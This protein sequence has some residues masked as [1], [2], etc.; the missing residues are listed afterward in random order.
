MDILIRSNALKD[1]DDHMTQ[2]DTLDKELTALVDE[3]KNIR[4]QREEKTKIIKEKN[5]KWDDLQ[6]QKDEA[7]AKFDKVRR[8]DES[9]YAE[10]V[11]TNKRRKAN[12]ASAK[13]VIF[14]HISFDRRTIAMLNLYI[15]YI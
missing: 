14:L 7:T 10:L 2:N 1:L 3:M 11:E 8:Q 9:L 15:N 4:R 5:K 12:I 13:T 6:R